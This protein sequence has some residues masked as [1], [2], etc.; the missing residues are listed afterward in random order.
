M[1]KQ[2]LPSSMVAAEPQGSLLKLLRL[3]CQPVRWPQAQLDS[4][5][6]TAK[7][8]ISMVSLPTS[9][10]LLHYSQAASRLIQKLA[11]VLEREWS[12]MESL[13]STESK[14]TDGKWFHGSLLWASSWQL[15]TRSLSPLGQGG[16]VGYS[17]KTLLRLACLALVKTQW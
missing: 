1:I 12:K 15:L 5:N 17:T 2:L 13:C 10:V 14:E 3:V 16:I 8:S 7:N 9:L 11:A 4:G 6:Y